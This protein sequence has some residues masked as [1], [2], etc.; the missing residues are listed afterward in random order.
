M[1]GVPGGVCSD[2]RIGANRCHR[3]RIGIGKGSGATRLHQNL[4]NFSL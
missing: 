1:D 2:G 4:L 3:K